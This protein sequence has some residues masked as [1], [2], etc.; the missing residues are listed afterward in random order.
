[1]DTIGLLN[2]LNTFAAF[3]VGLGAGLAFTSF[4]WVSWGAIIA[5]CVG[6]VTT[7]AVVF[8]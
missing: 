3:A 1:M 6:I 5:G 7:N 4:R 8:L 2:L